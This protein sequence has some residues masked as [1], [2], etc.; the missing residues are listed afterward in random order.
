ML[1]FAV[2]HRVMEIK[3]LE[4][5]LSIFVAGTAIGF[6]LGYA[7][8]AGISQHRRAKTARARILR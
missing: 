7:V 8:R 4:I 6:A 1:H 2:T 5:L 3:A